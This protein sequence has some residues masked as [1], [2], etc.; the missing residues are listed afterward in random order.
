PGRRDSLGRRHLRDVN[1]ARK[2][3]NNSAP[4]RAVAGNRRTDEPSR[5]RMEVHFFFGLRRSCYKLRTPSLTLRALRGLKRE[6][7]SRSGVQRLSFAKS[8]KW[9]CCGRAAKA[10]PV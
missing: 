1:R 9:R 6:L 7:V 5:N 4:G 10:R 3:A 2:S 8:T